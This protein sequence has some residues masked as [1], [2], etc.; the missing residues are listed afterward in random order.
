MKK[1]ILVLCLVGLLALAFSGPA[2]AADPVIPTVTGVEPASA[3]NDIDTRLTITGADFA[4]ETS[5]SVVT[6]PTISLGGTAGTRSLTDVAWVDT[7]TLTATLPWGMRPGVYTLT[8]TNP[9]GG[10]SDPP[11]TFTVTA[12]IGNWNAGELNGA[13]VTEL[14]MKP[15]VSP[16]E[17]DTLYALA[18]DVGL[19]RSDDAGANWKFTSAE[20]IGNAD[21][22]LDPNPDHENWLYSFMSAGLFVSRDKGDS[23]TKLPFPAQDATGGVPSNEVFVSP[24]DP[25]VLFAA[26]YGGDTWVG[27]KGLKKSVDAGLNWTDVPSMVGTAVQNVAFDPTPGSHKM[28][29]ATWDARVLTSADDGTT[30]TQVP[31]P[32]GITSIGS[33]GYLTYNPYYLAKPGEVWLSSTETSGGVFKTTITD[34]VPSWTRAE[35]S[36]YTSGYKVTFVGPDD[37]YMWLAH[38]TNGGTDWE[39]FGPS[40]TWGPGEFV[41]S[42]DDTRTIYF[43]NS[44]VGVQK[45]TTGGVTGPSGEAS[46][47]DA[48]NGLTGMR[49]V[50]MSVSTTDPLR[51]YATFNGWG[52]VYVSDDGTSHWKYVPI[53]G[54]G[55]M[56]QVLQD[57]FDRGLLYASGGGF[58]TSRDGGKTWPGGAW[59]GVPDS[60]RGLMGF[61]GMA[62]DPFR[63]GHLLV[64]ARVGQSST[65]DRDLGYLYSSDDHGETWTSVVV[66][67]TAGAIGPIGNIVFD[68]ETTGT[69][70]L[71]TAGSGIYRSRDHGDAGTWVR[72][73]DL[74]QPWM[75]NAYSISIATHPRRVLLVS[76]DSGRPFRS[77]DD[78]ATWENKQNSGEVGA[79]QYVFVDGDSTRLYA[80]DFFGLFFSN[81]V[82]DSW[83]RAAGVLGSVQN[84][85]LAH[86]QA[87]GHTLLY[88]AT[89]GGKTG[90]VIASSQSRS[91]TAR[92]ETAL[93]ATPPPSPLVGAGIYRRAQVPTTATFSSSGTRDGWVLESGHHSRRGGKTSATATTV[94][95]GDDAS[96]R[97]YRGILSFS[98]ASLP[99]DAVI[100]NVT[101]RVKKQ[102]VTGGGDPVTAFHGFM[103]D[104][105]RGY[106]GTSSTLQAGDFQASA[107]RS[108]G[109]FRPTATGGW[110]SFD[111]TG[112]KSYVN[113]VATYS[114]LTQIR[115]RFALD[116]NNNRVANYLSLYS[117]NAA[118]SVR[119]QLVVTYYVP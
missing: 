13:S 106:F 65:H 117:G 59:N 84:T 28:V 23:W 39:S 114:G 17:T 119:P 4:T 81:N 19:F 43:T 36:Y 71:A 107:S 105:K 58:Y 29:L 97:Q 11:G 15:K 44:T 9:D 46:W 89:T 30:W 78:G 63:E 51:V 3:F 95:L 16:N 56:W 60:Q 6:T 8:V 49:C 40:P 31:S 85:T 96:K 57:P 18:Y 1:L 50:S 79:R 32:P 52:G 73:D 47:T 64:S 98:T 82:A 27:Y 83:T 118:A 22:V 109:S 24:Q 14:L 62:A 103:V 45:S 75:A 91:A 67:G 41:F 115:L 20:V 100:T 66:T 61:G 101:L 68:P 21:F 42:P 69:V 70:Y 53:E 35:P 25:N 112:A 94:R 34:P 74:S 116:D 76:G 38:S 93:A 72:I 33:R 2:S 86:T 48:N 88:A 54:S 5:G 10:T 110:Y 55:Q 7:Q 102:G 87:D 90:I 26:T 108:Y 111:L 99:H 80:P 12:G 37:V 104:V 92:S 77:F 113:R